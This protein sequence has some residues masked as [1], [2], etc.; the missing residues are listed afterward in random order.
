MA[1]SAQDF[2]DEGIAMF[3]KQ[4]ADLEAQHRDAIDEIDRL[5]KRIEDRDDEID[6]LE[7]ELRRPRHKGARIIMAIQATAR[8]PMQPRKREW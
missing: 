8:D 1:K 6:G 2:I 7:D 4:I 3:E 5:T